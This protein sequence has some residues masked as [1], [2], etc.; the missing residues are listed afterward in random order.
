VLFFHVIFEKDLTFVVILINQ[1]QTHHR[2]EL[3]MAIA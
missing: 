2:K 1:Y 3:P